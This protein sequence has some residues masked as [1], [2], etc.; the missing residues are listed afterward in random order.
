[1]TLPEP[2]KKLSLQEQLDEKNRLEREK[3]ESGTQQAQEPL[4]KPEAQPIV[5]PPIPIADDGLS[6]KQYEEKLNKDSLRETGKT[7]KE[8]EKLLADAEREF[9]ASLNEFANNKTKWETEQKSRMDAYNENVRLWNV[10]FS[11]FGNSTR[12][13]QHWP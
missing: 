3:K 2:K 7:L 4:N 1:M 9:Q 12:S 11:R 10:V 8:R 6:L 5:D 13:R